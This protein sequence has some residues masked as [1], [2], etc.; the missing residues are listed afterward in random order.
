M[1]VSGGGQ[2]WFV[3]EGPCGFAW[4]TVK[5]ANAPFARYLTST[6]RAE[7]AYEGGVKV[8]VSAY[9][10][11]HDRKAAYA[12]AFARVLVEA[13]VRAVAGSRLD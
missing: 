10:Q 13:G 3:P 9:N 1:T 6:R 4:I 7:K 5:P 11:S 12:R 2:S 8:W